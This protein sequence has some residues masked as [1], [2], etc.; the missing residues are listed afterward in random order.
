MDIHKPK[1]VHNLREFLSEIT[2]IVIGVLIA[3]GLEQAVEAWHWHEEVAQARS[4]LTADERDAQNGF[5]FRALEQP[6]IDRRLT[7]LETVFK[8]HRAGQPL[9]LIAPLGRPFSTNVFLGS[10]QI[11]VTSQ[12]LAHMSLKERLAFNNR[13][14]GFQGWNVVADQEQSIW[15][16]LS[17][18]DHADLL[19]EQDW[20]N[21]RSAYA[22]ALAVSKRTRENLPFYVKPE[23]R[24]VT[25]IRKLDVDE[26][27]RQNYRAMCAP[28]IAS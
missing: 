2:I 10:W 8:R 20:S 26:T 16:R 5:V 11:A 17:L 6:C 3:L 21:L 1:P 23:N 28:M 12:A 18:I 9:G 13:F 4:T 15:T 25:D 7:A 19:T 24:T 14:G 22:E 27:Y